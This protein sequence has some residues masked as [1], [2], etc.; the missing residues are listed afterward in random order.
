LFLKKI[1]RSRCVMWFPFKNLKNVGFFE[2]RL[3]ISLKNKK[4]FAPKTL[5]SY[6]NRFL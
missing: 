3:L 1:R 2:K 5:V 4:L 6:Q